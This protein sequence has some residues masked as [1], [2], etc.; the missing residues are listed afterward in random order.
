M[1]HTHSF[2][3]LEFQ[4][5]FND[6]KSCEKYLFNL[7]WKDGFQCPKCKHNDYTYISTRKLYQCKSCKHQASLT[8]GTVMH[9]TRT[10]LHIWFWTIYLVSSDKRGCAALPLSKKLSISY[11]K[12]WSMIHKI[13]N[14]MSKRDAKYQLCN[15]AEIDDAYF[16]GSDKDT[17][18]GRGTT[19]AKVIISVSTSDK[20]KP[21]Y[22][23]MQVV[24]ELNQDSVH[25]FASEGIAKGTSI[26]SDGLN[27]YSKLSSQGYSHTCKVVKLTEACNY[28]PWVHILISNSKAFIIGTYHGALERKNLQTYLDEF[29]YRFNRRFW[30][31]QLFG[32]LLNACMVTKART[33]AELTQ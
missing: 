30:E 22:V 23:K 20:G 9:R 32:R 16:C 27:I 14:A 5:K 31:S 18:P 2:S 17:K 13:R 26:K 15:I 21:Q 29:C 10:P 6:E 11:W 25:D 33:F 19:K 7:R 4:Q 3:L 1:A 12:A 28:L 8:A 24:E